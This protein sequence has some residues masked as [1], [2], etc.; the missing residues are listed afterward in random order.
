MSETVHLGL[1]VIAAAQAQKH[2]THNEALRILDALVML[3][4]K[5]RDLSA[6]PGTP[7]DGDRYLV[8]P[9]GSD[10]FAGKDNQIA[11]FRDGTWAFYAPQ[12]GWLC[13]VEDEAAALVFDGTDWQPLPGASDEFQNVTRLGLGTTADAT[14]PLTAKLNNALWTARYDSE[15]GDGNLRTKLNK[16]TAADVLSILLQTGYSGR[17]EIG[18]IGDDDLAFKVSSD[19]SAWHDA[20]R[21]ERTSGKVSFPNTASRPVLT[22]NRT[23]YV[24]TDGSDGNDGLTNTSGGALAT[25]AK[26]ISLAYALDWSG[27]RVTIQLGAGTFPLTQECVAAFLSMQSLLIRGDPANPS[28]VI[29]SSTGNGLGLSGGAAIEMTGVTLTP[30]GFCAVNVRRG[31]AF[32]LG[33]NCR[34]TGSPSFG[35]IYVAGGLATLQYAFEIAA[36]ADI[37]LR[38][39]MAGIIEARGAYAVTLTGSPAFTRGFIEAYTNGVAMISSKT[40]SGAA[41]GPRY[42]VASGGVIFTNGGGASYFPG[43]AAGS[44][45]SPGVYI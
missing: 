26:A 21:V 16:E 44:V 24:R 12:S 34:M 3:S 42:A 11:H 1:P 5:D 9:P 25:I 7:A 4:V 14:N 2:V 28:S 17:A 41:T 15:G 33:A 13:Y 30:G 6:P 27:Y 35:W 22:A 43:N 19:G 8:H 45:T 32:T 18:L 23:Y 20:M 38:V 37:A 39:E 36:S 10:G 31:G 29:L 40:F